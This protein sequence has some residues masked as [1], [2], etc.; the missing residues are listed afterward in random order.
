MNLLCK[1][2]V[3]AST[4]LLHKAEEGEV[5]FATKGPKNIGEV[6]ARCLKL[7]F[8]CDA[9]K[10]ISH[11]D[12]QSTYLKPNVELSAMEHFYPCPECG[13]S[14]GESGN[15]LSISTSAN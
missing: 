6:T 4:S 13:H 14:N 8:T 10:T 11:I 7:V 15:K 2:V 9:C 12:P 1:L 3:W 5:V